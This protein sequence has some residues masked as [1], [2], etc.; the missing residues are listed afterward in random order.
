MLRRW[1]TRRYG[2]SGDNAKTRIHGKIRQAGG[3][4]GL[5][6]RI[7]DSQ[8]LTGAIPEISAAG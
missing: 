6:L 3:D 4:T 1:S 2:R 8:I 5:T 7:V